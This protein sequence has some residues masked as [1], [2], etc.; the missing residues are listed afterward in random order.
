MQ[1]KNDKLKKYYS[2]DKNGYYAKNNIKYEDILKEIIAEAKAISDNKISLS[3]EFA[4][5]DV[6]PGGE[7]IIRRDN[8][9]KRISKFEEESTRS[10]IMANFRENPRSSLDSYKIYIDTDCRETGEDDW[11]DRP[12]VVCYYESLNEVIEQYI[13]DLRDSMDEVNIEETVEE[14]LEEVI[15]SYSEEISSNI[16]RKIKEFSNAIEKL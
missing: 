10:G 4:I 11:L 8:L 13:S 15:E 14:F 1:Y 12:V 16:D 5:F 3:E 9:V 2:F 7:D 6:F